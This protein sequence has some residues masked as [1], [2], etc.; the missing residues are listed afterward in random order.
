MTSYRGRFTLLEDLELGSMARVEPPN[1]CGSM[2]LCAIHKG[3]KF[4]KHFLFRS[5]G[6]MKRGLPLHLIHIHPIKG[7]AC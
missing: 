6:H 4:L 7:Q 3:T 2:Y 5:V 1:I